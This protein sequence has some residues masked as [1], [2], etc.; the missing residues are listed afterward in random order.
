MKIILLVVAKNELKNIQHLHKKLTSKVESIGINYCYIDGNSTDGTI[1]YLNEVGAYYI[2]QKY[3][4]RGGAIL[5][6]FES[7]I[8]DG[9]IVFSPDGNE[10]IDDL[11]IIVEKL[12][13]EG[14]LVIASRMMTGARNEED[15]NIFKFRKWANNFFNFLINLL[16]NKSNYVTDSI[17]GFRGVT[18]STLDILKLDAADYTIE[19]QMTIRCM[20]NRIKISE[21]ATKEGQRLFGVTGAPSIKTGIAFLKRLYLEIIFKLKD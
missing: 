4:G 8:Y 20:K 16:F 9:Y 10:N 6:G 18:R 14:G 21:F 17:N 5:S 2:Q 7:L 13:H 1:E 11:G 12:M 3:P 15:N 19:Y